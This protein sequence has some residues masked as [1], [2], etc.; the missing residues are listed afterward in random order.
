[1]TDPKDQ[2]MLLFHEGEQAIT[3]HNAD[4]SLYKW[5]AGQLETYTVNNFDSSVATPQLQI[6]Y[7][8]PISPPML[9]PKSL[10]RFHMDID[11]TPSVPYNLCLSSVQKTCKGGLMG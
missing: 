9:P 5:E 10:S 7:A 6:T 8:P 3:A 11:S 1:M 4:G 2:N